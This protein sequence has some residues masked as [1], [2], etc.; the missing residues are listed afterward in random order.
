M[1]FGEVRPPLLDLRKAD[2]QS[3]IKIFELLRPGL[4]ARR[5][6]PLVAGMMSRHALNCGKPEA[7]KRLDLQ[8]VLSI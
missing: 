4:N 5:C 6:S 7:V 3:G 1:Q 8:L 2:G